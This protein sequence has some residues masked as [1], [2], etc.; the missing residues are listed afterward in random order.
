MSRKL[1]TVFG[2]VVA[3]ALMGGTAR[4]DTITLTQTNGSSTYTATLTVTGNSA[5]LT[6]GGD[7]NTLYTDAVA[8]HVA[9]GATVTSGT[10]SAGWTLQSGNNAVNCDGSGN[11]FCAEGPLTSFSG[12]SFTWNFT[13][14]TISPMSVQ[15]AVCTSANCD[16][17]GGFLTNFSQSGPTNVP[18]PSTLALLGVGLIALLGFGHRLFA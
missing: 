13:G 10:S 12:L 1:L 8:I 17:S 15:F 2:F 18:E 11:W 14:S 6:F 7:L 16:P 4:A 5:T 3:M 9:N